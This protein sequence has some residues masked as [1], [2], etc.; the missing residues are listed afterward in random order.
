MYRIEK[1]G[2]YKEYK[3][4]II[5]T[6]LGHRC[7]Y[8]GISPDHPLY[9]IDYSQDIQSPELLQEIKSSTIEK[10]CIVDVFCWDGK[11]TTPSMLFNV[12]GGIT[13]SGTFDRYPTNQI[14]PLWWFGFDCAHFEDGKDFN[15]A[16]K[17]FSGISNFDKMQA[18]NHMFE[19]SNF[20]SIRTLDYCVTECCNLI[21]QLDCVAEILKQTRIQIG[22]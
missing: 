17:Y 1:L 20:G 8:V 11:K 7:G 21:D 18:Y 13:Y 15:L 6:R 19:E 12:H 3:Y 9:N 14:D 4:V 10:R 16:H 2:F 22:D 5:F